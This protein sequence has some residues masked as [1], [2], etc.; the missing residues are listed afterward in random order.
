MP[1]ADVAIFADTQDEPE[2]VY[3]HLWRLVE[4]SPIPV[5]VCTAGQL[6]GT[7]LS[8]TFL[9]FFTLGSDDRA[10]PLRRKCTSQFKIEPI[11]QYVRRQIF[12]LKKGER[13]QQHATALIGI[14]FDEIVR[15]KPSLLSWM[16]NK[17]PLVDARITRSKCIQIWRQHMPG[18]PDPPRSA[19]VFCPYH[20]NTEWRRLRDQEPEAWDRAVAFDSRSR[21]LR[22]GNKQDVFLHRTL[23]PLAEVDLDSDDGQLGL[24]G[25]ECEGMCGV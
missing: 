17:W 24:W 18:W 1:R 5:H 25:A 4:W 10:A 3:E 12:A 15:M 21:H 20:S 9:P 23:Q 19:C 16:E 2:S 8:R 13:C 11:Q 22:A 7:N 14:S 6:S